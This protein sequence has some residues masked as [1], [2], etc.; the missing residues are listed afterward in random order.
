M[1]SHLCWLSLF[2]IIFEKYIHIVYC[3]SA[4]VSF[5]HLRFKCYV[6]CTRKKR[7]K[8]SKR[9]KVKTRD[10]KKTLYTEGWQQYSHRI[11]I[12]GEMELH[13]SQHDPGQDLNVP[14]LNAFFFF[15]LKNIDVIS[16]KRIKSLNWLILSCCYFSKQ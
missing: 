1:Y 9:A 11:Q 2:N 7:E 12:K 8:E 3:S 16:G 4:S 13:K 10:V 15:K 5:T 14:C 6:T